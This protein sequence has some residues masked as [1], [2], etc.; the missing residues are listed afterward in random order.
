MLPHLKQGN[1]SMAVLDG[2]SA[3]C[4]HLQND[5]TLLPGKSGRQRND[6]NAPLLA[7]VIT[8]ILVLVLYAAY[9]SKHKHSDLCPRC[10]KHSLHPTGETLQRTADGVIMEIYRCNNCGYTEPRE[11]NDGHGGSNWG[12]GAFLPPFIW[13]GGGHGG[14]GLFGGGG[15]SGGSFGGGSFGGGSFGGGG[16]GGKF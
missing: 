15:M 14:G 10:R 4:A 16:A 8:I 12:L 7:L 11:K 1:W 2:V 3:I 5:S 9:K 13:F 6:G